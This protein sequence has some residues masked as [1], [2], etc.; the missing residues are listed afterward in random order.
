[1]K[2]VWIGAAV[3]ALVG[4]SFFFG[5]AHREDAEIVFVV[6]VSPLAALGALMGGFHA[7]LKELRALR[8]QRAIDA[9]DEDRDLDIIRRNQ[10]AIGK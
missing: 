1:M 6:T 4:T 3:G 2:C 8:R 7:V 5:A 10:S 9:E